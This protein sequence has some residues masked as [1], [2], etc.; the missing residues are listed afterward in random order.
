MLPLTKSRVMVL[1]H[2]QAGQEKMP[3]RSRPLSLVLQR[4]WLQ[5]LRQMLHA[6]PKFLIGWRCE[7]IE[8]RPYLGGWRFLKT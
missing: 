2:M 7:H 8:F 6:R 1:T 3:R 5:L 4:R